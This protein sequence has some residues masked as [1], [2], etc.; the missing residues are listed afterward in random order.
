MVDIGEA[1]LA[2]RIS[3]SP[4]GAPLVLLHALGK[5][6]SD[7]D[8]VAAELADRWRLFV[9]DLRGHGRSDWPGSYSFELMRSDLETL[10]DTLS[11]DR[12]TL[13]GHSMGGVVAYLYAAKHPERVERLV[14]EETPPPVP[15][16]RVPPERPAGEPGFDWEAVGP[17]HAQL[18]DPTE[19]WLAGLDAITAPTLLVKGGL[20]S[21]VPQDEIALM[22]RR[23]AG[24]LVTIPCG[25]EIHATRAADFT[26]ALTGFLPGGFNGPVSR[27]PRPRVPRSG[28]R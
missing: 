9:P 11:L 4:G 20:R 19:E 16:E 21:H 5:D 8:A 12:V 13:V 14:L 3:G 17:L 22:A 18:S 10:L 27:S 1:R 6:G 15:R 7:W 25:H 26:A 23:L 2:C 28:P 24:R